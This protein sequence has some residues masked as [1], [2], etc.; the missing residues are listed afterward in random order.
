MY[1]PHDLAPT[2][3]LHDSHLTRD[4]NR[5]TAKDFADALAPLLRT[6]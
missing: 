1:V 3:F 2:T 5:Q 4:G 6:R